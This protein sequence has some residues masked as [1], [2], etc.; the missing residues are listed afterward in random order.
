MVFKL[1]A[2]PVIS[3]RKIELNSEINATELYSAL[4]VL[5]CEL[6]KNDLV[7]YVS[8][9]NSR[10]VPQDELKVTVAHKILKRENHF[11]ILSSLR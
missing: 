2:G 1:D 3:E 5:G 9:R 11:W 8:W 6:L 4:S 10:L 7:K